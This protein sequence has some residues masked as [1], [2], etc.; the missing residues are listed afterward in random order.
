MIKK[1]TLTLEDGS[2]VNATAPLIISASRRTDIPAFHGAWFMEQ[3]RK[4]YFSIKNP[5][6]QKV[7]F[8]SSKFSE[9]I[10]FWTKNPIPFIPHLIE[11]DEMGKD[12]YFQFTIN[13]YDD[14]EIE[15]NIP[16]LD[17]RIDAF[18]FISQ[19]YG[20]NS[21]VWR[22]DPLFIIDGKLTVDGLIKRVANVYHKL[23][24]VKR[25]VFSFADIN[26][27]R[28]VSYNVRSSGI[29]EM[30]NEEQIYFCEQLSKIIDTREVDIMTCSEFIDLSRFGIN[31]NSCVDPFII[32]EIRKEKNKI[33]LSINIKDNGQRKDCGC[34]ESK[35]I[36]FYDS[37]SHGC[38]YCYANTFPSKKI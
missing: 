22:F 17:R 15:P 6:N 25:L 18:K 8:V 12:F 19:K 30:N 10:V 29:R 37:C 34:I 20:S 26:S 9:F 11:I 13:D 2:S 3:M 33:P 35:D 14:L 7:S 31:H 1:T 38:L 21:V 4:G 23:G 16:K 28:K 24:K 36:G 32:N 5:F 27:Y